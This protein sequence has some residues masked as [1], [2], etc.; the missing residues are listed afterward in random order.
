MNNIN[1]MILEFDSISENESFARVVVAAFV[2]RLNPTLE[3]ISDIKTAISEAVTNCII[4]AYDKKEGKIK[5]EAR[6]TNKDIHNN[7]LEI[8]VADKGKGIENVKQAMEPMFTTKP[9]EE[10]SGMGFA[11]ME[12]FMNELKVESVVGQGTKVIMKKVLVTSD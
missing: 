1:E 6:I 7:L 4:H 11:F 9:H 5:I 12:A 8:I 3:E 10:R 2:T